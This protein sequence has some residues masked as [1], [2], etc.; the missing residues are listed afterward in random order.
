M[1]TVA[2]RMGNRDKSLAKVVGKV[3]PTG[4]V[5]G[6]SCRLEPPGWAGGVRT[7]QHERGDV[8]VAQITGPGRR[9]CF[10]GWIFA[11]TTGNAFSLKAEQKSVSF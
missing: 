7:S 4:W 11:F 9:C 5:P 8:H 2:L 1:I 3:L 6:H 10:L